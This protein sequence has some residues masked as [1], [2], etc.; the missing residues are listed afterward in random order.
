MFRHPRWWWRVWVVTAIVLVG[1]V[2]APTIDPLAGRMLAQISAVTHA[3]AVGAGRSTP[4]RPSGP[5]GTASA[6][7]GPKVPLVLTGL[8]DSVPSAYGCDCPGLV[9]G[10]GDRVAAVTGRQVGVHNDAVAGW[11]S[12]DLVTALADPQVALDLARSDLVVIEIGANDV[13]VGVAD[14][15]GCHPV[16]TSPCWQADLDGL[17][18]NLT[19][20]VAAAHAD[21][22]DPVVALLDYWNVSVDGAVAA[23]RGAA[24][25]RASDA[26]TK[27]VNAVVRSV[28]DATGSVYV[29][30]YSALK[31]TSGQRDPTRDLQADGDHP[32][33]SGHDR[34]AQATFD[35]LASAGALNAWMPPRSSRTP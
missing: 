4:S 6:A 12:N 29:D 9:Q 15:N 13:D 16:S 7:L 32:D 23:A 11:T 1:V 20:L 2:L 5:S 25:V 31:G 3:G 35:A 24:F 21:G 26:L 8:G 27:R 30:T 17:R 33:A 22:R 19:K 28:A 34:I 14:Q 10:V 18:S